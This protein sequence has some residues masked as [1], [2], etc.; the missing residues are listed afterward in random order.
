MLNN[1]ELNIHHISLDTMRE[2]IAK[3]ITVTQNDVKS[4][5]IIAAV[6]RDGL[7]VQFIDTIPVLVCLKPSGK[8][9]T[10]IMDIVNDRLEFVLTQQEVVE[11]G[12]VEFV[13][14]LYGLNGRRTSTMRFVVKVTNELVSTEDIDSE[15]NV[16]PLLVQLLDKLSELELGV[17]KITPSNSGVLGQALTLSDSG[18]VM[19]GDVKF[20]DSHITNSIESVVQELQSKRNS[21]D[22]II[23]ADLSEELKE[24]IAVVNRDGL[25]AYDLAVKEGFVG[26]IEEWLLSLKGEDGVI[27]VDGESAY[28]SWLKLGNVGTESDFITS[29]KGGN[30]KDFKYSDFTQEQLDSFK[31]EKGAYFKYSDFTREQLENLRGPKGL[32]GDKGSPFLYEDLTPRQKLELKG[33]NGVDGLSAYQ[34]ARSQGFVGTELEWLESLKGKDGVDVDGGPAYDDTVLTN[35]V[36]SVEN[37]LSNKRDNSVYIKETDLSEEVKTKLNASGSGA[38]AYDDTEVKRKITELEESKRD[39]NIKIEET[40]LSTAVQDKLNS[41]NGNG[42]E[43]NGKSAYEIAVENGF[44]GTEDEWLISLKGPKGDIGN[45]G[46]DGIIRDQNTAGVTGEIKIWTGTQTQ[47]DSIVTKSDNTL[48]FVR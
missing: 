28:Q 1:D 14:L 24:R 30:G 26:S 15:M 27:G 40:D 9:T 4:D 11:A 17:A 31:G 18:E 22:K 36:I 34:I 48:Y 25:S 41:S 29:L 35:R 16:S 6:N 39:K 46:A 3:T 33:D 45:T 23:E 7:P 21:S 37:A 32:P 42:N 5:K 38:P 20:D 2:E 43:V 12:K 47:Y 13:I 8:L 19:W 10:N 44:I